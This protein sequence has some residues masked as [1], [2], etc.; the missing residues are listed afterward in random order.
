M[1]YG[2]TV[3]AKT[4]AEVKAKVTESWDAIVSAQPIHAKD[5][6]SAE[7]C[8]LAFVD[9]LQDDEE[10]DVQ[11]HVYGSVTWAPGN[12]I[13]QADARVTATLVPRAEA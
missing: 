7:A 11:L 9:A 10:K 5:R 2:F 13:M 3:K 4:K 1:S 8:A 6:A 12:E